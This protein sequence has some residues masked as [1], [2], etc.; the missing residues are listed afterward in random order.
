MVLN[1]Q[2]EVFHLLV[3]A[4][5]SV[6]HSATHRATNWPALT[7]PWMFHSVH[8][9]VN[10]TIINQSLWMWF[11]K[12]LHSTRAVPPPYR[13]VALCM[14]LWFQTLKSEVHHSSVPIVNVR[15]KRNVRIVGAAGP[16]ISDISATCIVCTAH[17]FVAWSGRRGQSKIIGL[18]YNLP[19][20]KKAGSQ[21]S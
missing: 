3:P 18:Y 12:V 20:L 4:I 11:E 15:L 1:A 9:F 21:V 17:A 6:I 2:R 19:T 8:M 16:S 7:W 5:Q 14:C 13:V 10:F